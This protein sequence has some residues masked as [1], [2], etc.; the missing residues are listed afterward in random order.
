[1]K[2]YNKVSNGYAAAEVMQLGKCPVLGTYNLQL[3]IMN[4]DS[5]LV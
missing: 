3:M 2:A 1:M 4:C 5:V